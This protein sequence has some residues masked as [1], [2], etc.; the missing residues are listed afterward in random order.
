MTLTPR[1]K[2]EIVGAIAA[3]LVL[4]IVASS[5][6]GAREDQIRMKAT[7]D[8]Q[9][10]VIASAQKQAKDIQDAE[11]ARDK[12]TAASVAAIQSAAA[13]QVTPAEIAAW[14]PK[15]LGVP[16]PITLQVP[17]P[18]AQNP[19]PNATASIP[20][21]DLPALRDTITACQTC[22]VKLST[23]QAD[24]SSRDQ[25]AALAQKQI[26]ALKTERDVAVRASKGGGFWS[27]VKSKGKWFIIGGAVAGAAIC[28]TGHCK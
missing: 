15:Q 18:T 12:A 16:Q 27:R 20:E 7:I 21:A 28:G 6:L 3:A 26:D 22:S 17:A 2:W 25:Q 19:S 5:W 8:A 10:Q 4:A 14:I 24:L 1:A 23:A 13:K 11:D 9:N